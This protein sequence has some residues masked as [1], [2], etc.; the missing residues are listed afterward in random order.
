MFRDGLLTNILNPKMAIFVLALFPQFIVREAGSVAMQIMVL[1]TVLNAIGF[2]VNGCVI[3]SA[4][5]LGS[6]IAGSGR[7]RKLSQYFLGTVF[8]G[9]AARLAFDNRN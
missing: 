3:L 9:L 2:F 4:S 5:R 6:F 8:V 7:L 1:A